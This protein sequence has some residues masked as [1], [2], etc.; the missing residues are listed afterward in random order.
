MIFEIERR[1]DGADSIIDSQYVRGKPRYFVDRREVTAE[2]YKRLYQEAGIRESRNALG[3]TH[4]LDIAQI[5][6]G[7]RMETVSVDGDNIDVTKA[8][9][10]A[11]GA[12]Q[13]V[14]GSRR[15]YCRV[16][17]CA[18]FTWGNMR[19]GYCSTHLLFHLQGAIQKEKVGFPEMQD[20]RCE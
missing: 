16:E 3:T 9:V 18:E 17:G 5:R 4:Q 11:I 14:P 2:E 10:N 20:C 1:E 6:R 8:E 19:G 15:S 12:I 13:M 7:T